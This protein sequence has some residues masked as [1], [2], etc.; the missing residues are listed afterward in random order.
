MQEQIFQLKKSELTTEKITGMNDSHIFEKAVQFINQIG[1]ATEF[2]KIEDD[3]CFLPGLM[4]EKGVIIIDKSRLQ[5]PGDI[6]HEA[7]HLAVVPKEE[8]ITLNGVDIETRTNAAAEEMMAIAWSYAACIHLQID[9]LFV[10]HEHGY[11]GGGSWIA[12]NFKKG[13]YF[14]VPVLQWLGMTTTSPGSNNQPV[15]PAMLKWLRD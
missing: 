6:L 14:G 11:K 5:Y 9:P 1:I 12:E 4:I 15:Y 3:P 10:F 2:R 7:A 8:R 13:N